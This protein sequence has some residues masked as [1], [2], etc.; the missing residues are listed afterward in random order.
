I[1]TGTGY[2]AAL[3]A[4]RLG[5]D[6][7][8]SVDLDPDLIDAAERAI[9]SAGYRVR[10]HAG[11]GYEGLAEAAPFDRIIATCAITH[12]PPRWIHQLT[13]GGRIVAPLFVEGWPLAVLDKTAVDEVTGRIDACQAAFMP[14]RPEVD[15]PLAAGRRLGRVG[16]GVG[17][18]GTTDLDPHV[19]ADA[20]ADLRLFLAL[21]IP[22]LVTGRADGD[23]GTWITLTSPDGH[24]EA[25]T[26]AGDDG[27]WDAIQ[28]G[29]RL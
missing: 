8:S 1:G 17:H 28:H 3:L 24:A 7:V 27:R 13:P 12:V 2:N 4:H 11:D 10:L 14:L 26:T 16:S 6:R 22:G 5:G 21:H 9:V 29:Q 19:I 23:R 18:Y 20:D 25:S 15:N